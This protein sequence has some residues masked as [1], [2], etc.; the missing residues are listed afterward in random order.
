M[1]NQSDRFIKLQDRIKNLFNNCDGLYDAYVQKH[2]ELVIIYNFLTKLTGDL[3][4]VSKSIKS[5]ER[6]DDIVERILA[7][8]EKI[9]KDREG[10]DIKD[11]EALK[12]LKSQ[13][14]TIMSNVATIKKRVGDKIKAEQ[15]TTEKKTTDEGIGARLRQLFGRAPPTKGGNRLSKKNKSRK[16]KKLSKRHSRKNRRK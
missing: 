3:Q 9:I 1:S 13:Q 4:Y 8:L 16:N 11:M 7:D 6:C 14:K 5:G 12:K 10:E 15:I 2:E